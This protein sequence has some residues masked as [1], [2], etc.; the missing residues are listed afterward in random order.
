MLRWN[1]DRW[2]RWDRYVFLIFYEVIFLWLVTNIHQEVERTTDL[3]P[4]VVVL[5]R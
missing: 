1:R 3:S 2:N 5:L 4:V